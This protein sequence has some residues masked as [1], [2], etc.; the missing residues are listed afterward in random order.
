MESANRIERHVRRVGVAAG[1]SLVAL[2]VLAFRVPDGSGV[3]G[4]DVILAISP[5]GELG[6]SRSGPFLTATGMQPGS[7]A[8]SAVSVHNQT[9]RSLLVGLRALPDS[10]D[11]DRVLRVEIRSGHATRPVFTGLLGQLRRG[12]EIG[13]L[14]AGDR[15]RLSVRAWIPS[16]LRGGYAGRIETV[17][18]RLRSRVVGAAGR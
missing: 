14:P 2:I 13:T 8:R 15:R 7:E 5:T 10:P 12:A 3:L 4:A 1:V 18:L 9:G 17:S 6:V 16:T 11:L